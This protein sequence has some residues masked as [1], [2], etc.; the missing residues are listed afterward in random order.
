MKAVSEQPG[1]LAA[2]R[3]IL[4]IALIVSVSLL[5]MTYGAFRA[6]D[7]AIQPEME[8][9]SR[10]IGV[11]V[12]DRFERALELGIPLESISGVDQFFGQVLADFQ[13]VQSIALLNSSGAIAVEAR[14]QKS[15]MHKFAATE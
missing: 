8:K 3:V 2:R 11:T 1:R 7:A 6:F 12:R 4:W 5:V 14:P 15:C 9:R 13:D 10:L